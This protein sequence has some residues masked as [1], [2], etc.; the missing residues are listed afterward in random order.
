MDKDHLSRKLAVILHAD[1]V[2]STS[3]VQQNET[4]AHERIRA[5]FNNFSETIT[6]FGGVAREIRGD[7]LVA[8]F[9]RASDAVAAAIAFQAA[10]GELNPT[11]DDD[12]QPQLRMG[13]SLGEVVIADNTITGAGVVLAQRLEQLSEPGG[14]CI[15]G[16]AYETVPRRFPFE[17]KNL[18]EQKLKGF[19][20]PVQAYAITLKPDEKIPVPEP[21]EKMIATVLDQLPRTAPQDNKSSIFIM[22]FK[23]DSDDRGQDY[24]AK[25]I[26]DNII[27]ALTRFRGLFVFAYKT[28]AASDGVIDT[29][30]SAYEQLGA[31]YVVEGSVQRSAD[32]IRISARLVD[33]RENQHLWAQNYD[34]KPDDIILIQDEIA[35][36]I[37]SSLVDTVEKT[38]GQ[39]VQKIPNTQLAAYDLVLKGRVLLNEYTQEG[40]MAARECFQKAIDLDSSYAPAY[41]GMAVS[42]AHEYYE[43][44]CKDPVQTNASAYDF[45]CKAVKLDDTNIMGLYAL[46]EAFY[47]RGEHERA[48][49][50]IDR[51]IE[52]NPNDYHNVCAKG[53]YLTLS[54]QFQAGMQCS[55]D[56]MS[57]NPLAADSCLKVIG[58]GEYLSG[59]FDQALIAFSKVKRNSL[60]KLG[61]IAACYAQLDRT[62]EATRICD[63]FFTLAGGVDAEIENWKDY[64]SRTCQFSDPGD[65]EKIL[66]GMQKAGIPVNIES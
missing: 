6:A 28:S 45:A 43:T 10:N 64:W 8:E 62:A 31:N 3:L 11:L 51:A 4:L 40:E 25:G 56:A 13:I 34:R 18:G 22:P 24:V 21:F 47:L 20:T 17:Y 50:E 65:R 61:S 35:E 27:I 54:G 53:E 48:V 32:R 7:A 42:F 12:I 2:G 1:V 41:A 5:A 23:N 58:I 66:A 9:D 60:F 29:A 59:N 55:L 26:T 52:N 49:I 30:A 16:A 38:D 15:Q 63:E 36:L 37:V 39:R 46:A 19:E 33:A 44:W 14:V 57:T